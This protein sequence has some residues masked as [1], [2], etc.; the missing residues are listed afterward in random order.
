MSAKWDQTK[1][2]AALKAHLENTSRTVERVV[3]GHAF[4]VAL[5]ASKLTT[6]THP[7]SIKESL[8]RYI[9]V[10]RV[11]SSGRVSNVRRLRFTQGRDHPAPLA[12]LIVNARR[13]KKNEP[14]LYGRAM[15]AAM[16]NLLKVRNRSIAFIAS[17]WIPAIKILGRFADKDGKPGLEASVVQV[18]ARKGTATPARKGSVMVAQI[19]NNAVAKHDKK[20]ALAHYGARGLQLAFDQETASI[21]KHLADKLKPEELKAN[22]RLA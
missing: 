10:H 8:G 6:K 22:R 14:G 21:T 4:H 3:N 11:S 1:F 20:G 16:R 2:N 15:T 9:S 18:G 13:G 12:A 17:G 5:A 7:T 19:I